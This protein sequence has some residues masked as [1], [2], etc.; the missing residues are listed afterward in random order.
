MIAQMKMPAAPVAEDLEGVTPTVFVVDPDPSTGKIVT[1]L[2]EGSRI[3][4]QAHGSGREF[5]SAYKPQHS[6]C[7]V[8]EQRI[9]DTSGLQIQRRLA[10]QHQC[11]P[12]VYVTSGIDVSTAVVLMRG[13]AVHILE[14][15]LRSIEL[16]NAIQE[17]LARDEGQRKEE[18][19]KRHVRESVAVL[20]RKERQLVGLLAAAKST[21]VIASELSICARA[22]ELRRRNVMEKL[23]LHSS[24]EL[25]RFAVLARQKFSRLLEAPLVNE[26]EAW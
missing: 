7:L 13:G 6:G 19:E 23:G 14:K 20:T 17:A 11:L 12:M 21:K 10:E 3:H 4:V 1:D 18:A 8:L 24:L 5:F 16:L 2:L 9:L 15:P 22:V 25:M 26:E